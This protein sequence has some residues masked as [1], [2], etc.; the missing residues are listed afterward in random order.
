MLVK[1][2][3]LSVWSRPHDLQLFNPHTTLNDTHPDSQSSSRYQ[4]LPQ[5][6]HSMGLA[7]LP[8][9]LMRTLTGYLAY[10]LQPRFW[11]SAQIATDERP[12]DRSGAA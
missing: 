10:V 8:G 7:E 12:V 1:T 2:C 6:I 9:L 11:L 5:V 4:G 3:L